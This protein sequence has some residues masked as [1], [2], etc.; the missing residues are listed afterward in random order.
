MDMGKIKETSA[1]THKED[2]KD[3]KAQL[4]LPEELAHKEQL[5]MLELLDLLDH[6]ELLDLVEI[7]EHKDHADHK[8]DQDL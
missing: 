6:K 8:E 3:H 7:K 5:E 2:L 1:N 4:D